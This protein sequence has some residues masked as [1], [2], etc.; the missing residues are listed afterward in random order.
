LHVAEEAS[1]I[2]RAYRLAHLL[3]AEH[4]ADVHG[5][6]LVDSAFGN[7][8]QA[9]DAD[10]GDPEL[11]RI[12]GCDVLCLRRDRNSGDDQREKSQ[13]MPR[14]RVKAFVWLSA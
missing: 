4:I 10:I 14:L 8:L 1:A 2:E 12:R 13:G 11:S 5:Q 9:L 7:A 3:H 6:V